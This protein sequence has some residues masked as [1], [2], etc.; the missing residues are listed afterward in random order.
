[1]SIYPTLALLE[2]CKADL[3]AGLKP[4]IITGNDQ[5][6]TVE[7]LAGAKDIADRV[8]IWSAE[9]FLVTRLHI[10]S[11]FDEIERATTV[12]QL[13]SMYNTLIDRYET[14]P[15]LRISIGK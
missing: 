4:I 7:I 13:V 11:G 2:K 1:M 15:S 14:D 9:Q 8:E 10:L 3:A 12:E 5:V 6:E